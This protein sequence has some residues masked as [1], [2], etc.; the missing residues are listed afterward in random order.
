VSTATQEAERHFEPERTPPVIEVGYRR[1]LGRIGPSTVAVLCWLAATPIAAAMVRLL[2]LD[3]LTLRG[4][5]IPVA[6]G[7]ARAAGAWRS[8]S[9]GRPT[10][11]PA[12]SP[13][14]T[15]PGSRWCC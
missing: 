4:A 12:A 8:P 3:P 14:C 2:G 13:G 5:I 11:W 1:A 10:G 9:A 7:A 15:Q 6:A